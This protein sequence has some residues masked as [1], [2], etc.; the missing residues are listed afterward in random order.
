MRGGRCLICVGLLLSPLA[1]VRSQSTGPFVAAPHGIAT[2]VAERTGVADFGLGLGLAA[3]WTL[4]PKWG[5]VFVGD[6]S[7]INVN[8]APLDYFLGMMALSARRRAGTFAGAP[9]N[10]SV[11]PVSW[12]GDNSGLGVLAGVDVETELWTGRRTLAALELLYF[13]PSSWRGQ[14]PTTELPNTTTKDPRLAIRLR[15]GRLL[16]PGASGL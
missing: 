1:A 15:F 7:W 16:G 5:V 10:L 4:S 2:L 8:R 12:E 14:N 11:G 13:A 9:L 3:G 6:L